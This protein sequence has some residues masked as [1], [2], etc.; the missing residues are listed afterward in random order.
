MVATVGIG[1][2][3]APRQRGQKGHGTFGIAHHLIAIAIGTVHTRQLSACSFLSVRQ[4]ILFHYHNSAK[5]FRAVSHRFSP[6]HN[7]YLRAAVLINLW[8]VVGTP[9]L[10]CKLGTVIDEQDSI[11]VHTVDNGLRYGTACLNGADTADTFQHRTQRLPHGAF[12]DLTVK[13]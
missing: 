2:L 5:G 11:S 10:S 1:S 12:Y 8:C 4:H 6:F 7:F 9:L 3:N 13:L